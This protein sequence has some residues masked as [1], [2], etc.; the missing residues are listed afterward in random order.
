MFLK[1]FNLVFSYAE[2]LFIDEKSKPLEIEDKIN[3]TLVIIDMEHIKWY[4]Q[5]NLGVKY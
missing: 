4:I 1:A 2:V 3:I 5:L